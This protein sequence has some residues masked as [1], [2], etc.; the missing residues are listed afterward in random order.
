[1]LSRTLDESN[2]LNDCITRRL[3][4]YCLEDWSSHFRSLVV[5]W[6]CLRDHNQAPQQDEQYGIELWG[7]NTTIQS[8]E[9]MFEARYAHVVQLRNMATTLGLHAMLIEA[10]LFY[11]AADVL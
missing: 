5:Y 8:L 6:Y 1:M 4:L 10:I 9:S 3:F 7:I 11:E 2:R